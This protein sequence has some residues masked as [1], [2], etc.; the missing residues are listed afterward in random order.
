MGNQM[1][2]ETFENSLGYLTRKDLG[3]SVDAPSAEAQGERAL[4]H[5]VVAL[6]LPALIYQ[7]PINLLP[8][9]LGVAM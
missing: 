1:C 3:V 7:P 9:N 6:P 4:N 5:G 2:R 8:R